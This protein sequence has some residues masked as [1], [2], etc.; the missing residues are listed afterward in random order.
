[1]NRNKVV[2]SIPPTNRWADKTDESRVGIVLEVL[3]RS[4]A[5][6][7]AGMVSVSRVCGEQQSSYSY[8]SLTFY[9]KLQKRVKNRRRY[10]K[11][12][13]SRK[14]NGVCEKDEEST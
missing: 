11:K 2:D 7:L 1:M 12:R 4:Q 9:G 14:S 3:C 5:E 8:E 13:K 6:G 10:K